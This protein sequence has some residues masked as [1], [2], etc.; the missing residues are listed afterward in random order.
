MPTRSKWSGAAWQARRVFRVLSEARAAC[1]EKYAQQSVSFR[2]T[3]TAQ[4]SSCSGQRS[5]RRDGEQ[6]S[7]E[8]RLIHTS[9]RFP[10]PRTVVKN[11]ASGSRLGP[12][13]AIDSPNINPRQSDSGYTRISWKLISF[14]QT[15]RAKLLTEKF[16]PSVS[17]H[18]GQQV[19][20]LHSRVVKKKRKRV[21]RTSENPDLVC[22][23]LVTWC[24]IV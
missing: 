20:R 19:S 18:L 22:A 3:S 7:K 2:K 11:G 21:A 13:F 9:W 12:Q 5:Y 17:L 8:R 14:V 15:S 4:L 1:K 16:T 6:H 23:A 24:V 10:R